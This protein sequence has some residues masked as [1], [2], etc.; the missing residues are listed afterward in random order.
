MYTVLPPARSIRLLSTWPCSAAVP[1][2][3]ATVTVTLAC[4][5]PP[6]PEQLRL[7]IA[8]A[9][10]GPTP[11]L[12]VVILLPLHAPDAVQPVALVLDQVSV[13]F[14]LIA[15]LFG[16]ALSMTVG[17]GGG[18]TALTVTITSR[19]TEPP[20]PVQAREKVELDV[21]GPVLSLPDVAFGPLQAPEAVHCVVPPELQVRV[22][23]APVVTEP[24]DA[25]RVIDGG[26]GPGSG[27]GSF[28]VSGPLA[29]QPARAS[30]APVSVTR[31]RDAIF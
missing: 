17:A 11:W 8:V 16:A 24:L 15:T 22:T 6:P 10:K 20:A 27:G 9:F 1:A 30:T 21:S 13:E 12:P 4:A 28:W 19:F 7:N 25:E 3:G 29:A 23:L 18:G 26:V 5:D 14:P 31:A 2:G